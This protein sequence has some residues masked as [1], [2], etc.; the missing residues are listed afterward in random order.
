MLGCYWITCRKAAHLDQYTGQ[1]NGEG[2]LYRCMHAHRCGISVCAFVHLSI[3]M[4]LCAF[5]CVHVYGLVS[6]CEH[7]CVYM[8]VQ[9]QYRHVCTCLYTRGFGCACVY[10]CVHIQRKWGKALGIKDPSAGFDLARV[11]VCPGPAQTCLARCCA[12]GSG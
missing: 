8:C 1:G 2:Y 10:M 4:C 7:V 5:M 6:L 11:Y 9:C 12:D 3:F